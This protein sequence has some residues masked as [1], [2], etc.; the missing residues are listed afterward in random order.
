MRP[1]ELASDT[2]S[3][4]EVALHGLEAVNDLGYAADL[5][6]LLQPTSPLT[7]AADVV[8]AVQ[9]HRKTRASVLS[10]CRQGHPIEW[11]YSLQQTGRLAPV[12][13]RLPTRRQESS[14]TYR[15]N[16]AIYVIVPGVLRAEKSF[17][18]AETRG[19]LMPEERSVDIDVAADL[20]C[21]EALLPGVS[22][23][24]SFGGHV[25]G[26][27]NPC[28]LIAEAG[29][30]HNGGLD[31]ALR[32]VD[33]AAEA[34]A[35]AVKFQS[36]EAERVVGRSARQAAYQTRNTGIEESQLDMVRRLQLDEAAHRRLARHCE[37]RSILFLSTPF[38]EPSVDL[39]K[40]L[41]VPALK[42]ASG[43]V[44]HHRLLR[45]AARQGLPILLSTG[46]SALHEVA[47]ALEVIEGAG[48]VPVALLHCVSNY[49]ADPAD[50]HLRAIDTM[51][52]AFAVPTGWSDHT[53]GVYVSVAAVAR[54]ADLLE[55]HFTLDKSLPGPDHAASLSPTELKEWVTA[56]RETEKALGRGEKRRQPSEEDTAA[57]V[58]RS[59]HAARDLK[60]GTLLRP[61][62]VVCLRPGT[63]IPAECLSQVL[64]K[65]LRCDFLSGSI[66]RR[67]DLD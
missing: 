20:R 13:A 42:I 66:L 4:V 36:F 35:D 8:E 43:E 49:P 51:R 45:H 58:R 22:A 17:L 10:V 3:T 14:P 26:P 37:E 48:P 31:H 1:S 19:Y 59:V 53:L 65:R 32:L 52:A 63:G 44:T 27:G 57:V 28:F 7:T 41:G 2:A 5:L 50:C 25:V 18:T 62:D 34:G 9:L 12:T 55:K 64:G 56:V 15:P 33:A 54:G 11:S 46:M 61:E 60:K 30:N 21:A 16:G 67:E 24:V 29:V 47:T 39:L 38:D 23:P 40:E 6:V